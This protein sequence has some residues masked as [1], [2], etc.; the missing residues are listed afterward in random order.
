M[1]FFVTS[2][3]IPVHVSEEGKG[4]KNLLFLHGYLETLYIWK[5]FGDLLP[6]SFHCI[7]IDL[8]GH[9]LTGT[10]PESNDM[11]FDADVVA[12]VLDKLSVKSV[13]IIGHSMGG[14]VAQAFL[15]KYPERVL[16][17]IHF[18]SNVHADLPEKK[19]QRLKEIEFIKNGKLISLAQIAVPNMY[20]KTNLR[21][22]DDKIQETIEIC[23]MHDPSGIAATVRGLMTRP[24][25]LEF[26][27]TVKVPLLFIFG[28]ADTYTDK[29]SADAILSAL[30]NAE[31]CFITNTGHN[32][33]IENPSEVL[34]VFLDF[35][36]KNHLV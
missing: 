2:N 14:Y 9:G 11:E 31:G 8:P 13:N 10:H 36:N 21:D 27:K 32:S 16:S 5:D 30:P 3:G 18:N 7:Y 28:T 34:T 23:E 33:F 20:S 12:G 22:C 19:N 24:D 15:K 25:N 6:E 35:L 4:D 1:E 17:L 26:L 29:T